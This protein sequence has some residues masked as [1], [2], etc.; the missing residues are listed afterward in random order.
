MLELAVAILVLLYL[1]LLTLPGIE[2][3]AVLG[4]V[5]AL[6]GLVG[7]GSAGLVYHLRLRRALSRLEQSTRGWLWAPVSRHALLDDDGR[8]EVLPW[9]RIGA[10]GFFVCVAGMVLVA[11]A[12]VRAAL[13]G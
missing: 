5:A 4:A 3:Q 13:A 1:L 7:G 12:I 9:F 2:V 10:A 8:R 11:V 6:G